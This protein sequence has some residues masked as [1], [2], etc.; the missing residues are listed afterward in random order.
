MQSK[1]SP[2][3]VVKGRAPDYL[4]INMLVIGD[5]PQSRQ[6]LKTHHKFLKQFQGIAIVAC[7][8]SPDALAELEAISGLHLMAVNVDAL[9][10]IIHQSHYPLVIEKGAIWQ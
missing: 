5:D 8:K 7:V 9:M 4:S 6:W 3:V 1:A 10:E 2:G